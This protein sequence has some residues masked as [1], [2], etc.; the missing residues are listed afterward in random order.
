MDNRVNC[1]NA[2]VAGPATMPICNQVAGSAS[3]PRKAQRLDG[4][5]RN[6]NKPSTSA[7][8][9]DIEGEEIV[10][11]STK[12]EDAHKQRAMELDSKITYSVRIT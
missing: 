10:R 5:E 7:R 2:K 12:V 4:E 3:V 8:P 1:R 9:L 11:Y 6:T